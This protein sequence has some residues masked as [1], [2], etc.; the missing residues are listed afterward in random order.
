MICGLGVLWVFTWFWFAVT[1]LGFVAFG[2]FL[3]LVTPRCDWV[4][5]SACG[6]RVWFCVVCDFW[7][8]CFVVWMFMSFGVYLFVSVMF[9]FID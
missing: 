5:V 9:G 1:L 2:V 3:V 7:F 8:V 6:L 4:L